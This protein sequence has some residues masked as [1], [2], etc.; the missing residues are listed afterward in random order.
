[1]DRTAC[2][3]KEE[4]KKF[5]WNTKAPLP[6]QKKYRDDINSAP[7]Q[8]EHPR[9]WPSNMKNNPFAVAPIMGDRFQ[10][11]FKNTKESDEWGSIVLANEDADGN[12]AD[13]EGLA[14]TINNDVAA[15][16]RKVRSKRVMLMSMTS[17]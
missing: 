4:R 8:P 14:T 16:N 2:C 9:G 1:M 15:M 12:V 11:N 3:P 5:G 6:Q 17:Q 10:K 7:E 13:N